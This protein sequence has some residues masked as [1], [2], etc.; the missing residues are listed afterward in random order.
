MKVKLWIAQYK[1]VLIMLLG[2]LAGT[3]YA[4]LCVQMGWKSWDVFS[5][6]YLSSYADITVNSTMLWQYVIH[7]R[8]RDFILLSVLGLTAL[9]RPALMTYLF[10]VGACAGALMSSAIMYYGAGGLMIY[11]VSV[12]PQYVFYGIALFMMYKILYKRNA[13]LKNIGIVLG[14][15]LVLLLAGTYTEA[16]I[17]PGM[18]KKL[19]VYL[20]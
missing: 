19:Y 3:G 17:N 15:A 8:G 7:T 6:S 13:N 11:T 14:I 1:F 2:I 20:Y 4:N 5:S 12:L 18:L 10:Y 9:C 16:Y